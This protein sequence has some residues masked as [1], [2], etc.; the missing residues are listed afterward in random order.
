[1]GWEILDLPLS[2]IIIH[3]HGGKLDLI[4]EGNNELTLRI[5]L[6]IRLTV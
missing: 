2:R 6:P 1:M 4:R 5:E 3:R